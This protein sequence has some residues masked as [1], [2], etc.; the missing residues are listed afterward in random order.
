[1]TPIQK[2]F[3]SLEGLSVGDAFGQMFFMPDDEASRNINAK[4]L[5][6]SPWYLTDDTIM[7]IGV[8]ETL[9]E[10]DKIDPDF[11]ASRFATNYTRNPRRGYGGMAHHILQA[12]VKGE[13]WRTV[14]PSV[15]DGGGSY[16]NGAAMRAAPIGA[17]FAEQ[18][19]KIITQ[20]KLSAAVTH[21]H[22]DGIAGAVA[23][24][25]VAGWIIR[26]GPVTSEDGIKILEYA[27]ECVGPGDTKNGIAKALSLP[28]SYSIKT[29]VSVLGNGEMLAASDTVPLA[30]WC[31]A[32]HIN[33]YTK[34]LWT[35]VSALGDRDTTCAIVGSLV[36]LNRGVTIPTEWTAARESLTNWESSDEVWS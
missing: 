35:T 30:L 28:F 29:A 18:P 7:S 2:A 26:N 36:A 20:A 17:Y 6:N 11:L 19:E 21:S 33:D 34:A 25:A 1:M 12:F 16:G 9:E 4:V 15:F 13:D 22:R 14:A 24:A 3:L 32:K 10:H 31:V 27:L 8:I 23:V 5:P